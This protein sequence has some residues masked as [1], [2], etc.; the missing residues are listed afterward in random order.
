MQGPTSKKTN[1]PPKR[2]N[3][4][5]SVKFPNPPPVA[6]NISNKK[7]GGPPERRRGKYF[8]MKTQIFHH[9]KI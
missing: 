4:K 1:E 5:G 6:R 7:R 3:H 8:F 9:S 2:A